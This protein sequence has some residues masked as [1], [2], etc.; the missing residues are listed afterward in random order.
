M[1]RRE[2]L[3]PSGIRPS[4]PNLDTFLADASRSFGLKLK[5]DRERPADNCPTSIPQLTAMTPSNSWRPS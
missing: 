1:E 2:L 4:L 3:V 5:P